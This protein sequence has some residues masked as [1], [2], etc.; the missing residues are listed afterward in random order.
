MPYGVNLLSCLSLR[1]M[2]KIVSA[3]HVHAGLEDIRHWLELKPRRFRS[4]T[5]FAI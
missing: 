5:A 3:V 2:S 1:V 4:P